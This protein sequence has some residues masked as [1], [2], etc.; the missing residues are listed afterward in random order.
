MLPKDC[1]EDLNIGSRSSMNSSYC[2]FLIYSHCIFNCLPE[3]MFRDTARSHQKP[4]N[5]CRW[6]RLFVVALIVFPSLPAS[7]PQSNLSFRE[8]KRQ[9]SILTFTAASRKFEV[10]SRPAP[11][12][13][14][15]VFL[16]G[17]T[18]TALQP[19]YS[20]VPRRSGLSCEAGLQISP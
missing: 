3:K 19:I 17:L 20:P 8:K 6:L 15:E 7:T 11:Q 14:R 16:L 9:L 12:V 18:Y 1:F 10:L 2:P 4:L 5:L 13:C